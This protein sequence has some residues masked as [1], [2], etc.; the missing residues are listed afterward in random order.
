[1]IFAF[2][3]AWCFI[4]NIHLQFFYS[5]ACF[6]NYDSF[7]GSI[8]PYLLDYPNYLPTKEELVNWIESKNHS[9]AAVLCSLSRDLS[10]K[11]QQ[12]H[13]MEDI[14]GLVAL[15]GT[16]HTNKLSRLF[17]LQFLFL[18]SLFN[19]RVYCQSCVSYSNFFRSLDWSRCRILAEYLGEDQMLAVVCKSFAAASALEKYEQNGEVDCGHALHAKASALG[20]SI[21]GRFLVM[22][23]E[24]IR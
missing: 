3:V 9:A 5:K 10:F 13:F 21:N 20:K 6:P 15:L 1:M 18:N 8:K 16:V 19:R 23:L 17:A 24:N 12:N 7:P 22:C 4:L 14:V 2:D 11:E